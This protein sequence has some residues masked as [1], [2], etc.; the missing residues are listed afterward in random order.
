MPRK[1]K[2]DAKPNDTQNRV[3]EIVKAYKSFYDTTET[4]R[5]HMKED[6]DFVVGGIKQW[7]DGD[8]QEL[9]AQKRPVLSFN[10]VQST[11]NFIC[12]VH[13]ERETDYRYF[14]RGTEDEHLGRILTSQVKYIMDRSAG[15]HEET[16]QFRMGVVAGPSVLEVA[17]DYAWTDDLV[18]GDISLTYL[19]M[20]SWYCDTLSRRYDKCDARWQ[21]KLMWYDRETANKKWPDSGALF[22]EDWMPYDPQTTGVG[23]HLLRELYDKEGDRIRVLQHWYRIPVKATL[24]VNKAEMDPAKAVMRVKDGDEAEAFLKQQYDNAGAVAAS[25]Y[26]IVQDQNLYALVNKQTGGMMPLVDPNEGDQFIEQVRKEAGIQAAAQFEV[27]SREAYAL[28]VSHLTGWE[29]LDDKPSPSEDDWRYP[30]SFFCPFTDGESFDDWKGVTRDLKDPQREINWHHCTILD[31]LARA[32]KGATWLDTASNPNIE[33]LKKRLPRAGFIGTYSGAVPQYWPPASFSPGDLAM[34]EVGS[35]FIDTISGVRA[36]MVGG[37][38][39]KTRSG[40]AVMASQAGGMVGLSTIFQNWQRT[41]QYTGMLLAKRVQQFHS[42]EKMDRII[43]QEVR[44]QQLLGLPIQTIVPPAVMYEKYRQI[45]E[46]DFDAVVGFQDASA[47]A[48]EANLNRMLQ[49]MA[50]GIPVPPPII[51]EMSDVPYKEEIL[52]ALKAQGMQP[53][54]PEMT[55][56]LT[57]MQGQSADGVNK[58]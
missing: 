12:G 58:S 27:V 37:D 36:S 33:D 1:K 11:I 48:R 15:A 43:G 39:A 19:A 40:R 5:R 9:E 3:K 23:D 38:T 24:I 4:L 45:K 42:P 32:P 17:H 26:Q 16:K 35:D 28:R 25:Q 41:K 30:F 34:M 22:H 50:I 29:L 55:K 53:P 47:T 31:T 57:G 46:L 20:N 7:K 6:L 14:P 10:K 49:F 44:M 13:A 2:T 52:A 56:A 21:G 8:Y 51:I 54:N 18:E